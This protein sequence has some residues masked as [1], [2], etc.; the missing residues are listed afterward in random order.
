MSPLFPFALDGVALPEYIVAGD[1]KVQ[2]PLTTINI[3]PLSDEVTNG[4]P[5][6][7]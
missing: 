4:R 2:A 3:F 6:V 1:T 5:D 7:I